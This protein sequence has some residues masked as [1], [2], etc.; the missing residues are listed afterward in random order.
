MPSSQTHTILVR[1]RGTAPTYNPKCLA[2]KHVAWCDVAI[3]PPN[4]ITVGQRVALRKLRGRDECPSDEDEPVGEPSSTD[5]GIE[6]RVREARTIEKE[7]VEFVVENENESSMTELV[8]L[9]V[10]HRLAETHGRIL[11]GENIKEN[12][13]G[14]DV[15]RGGWTKRGEKRDDPYGRTNTINVACTKRRINAIPEGT[16]NIAR[17]TDRIV[18][19]KRAGRDENQITNLQLVPHQPKP[20]P[21]QEGR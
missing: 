13:G 21:Q 11:D 10:E 16:T 6:G 15:N 19:A 14:E 9:T 8:Y 2:W 12:A 3:A 18:S 17:K 7:V 1:V 20:L 4:P 5:L